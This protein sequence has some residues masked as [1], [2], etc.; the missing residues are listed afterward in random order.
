ME[1]GEAEIR[2]LNGQDYET[3]VR[4][5]L[6]LKAAQVT[7]SAPKTAEAGTKVNV[8]WTGPDHKGDFITIVPKGTPEKK[9][10]KYASTR[11][12]SPA[13]IMV[14]GDGPHEIRYLA[15]QDYRTLARIPITITP[16]T[17]EE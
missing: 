16:A 7:L 12:G 6:T 3:L 9:W 14:E 8:K 10:K 11:G 13:A 15:G 1:P 2:Y 17:S 4:I 5:P